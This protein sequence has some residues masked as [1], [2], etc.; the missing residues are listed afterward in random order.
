MHELKSEEFNIVRDM[1]RPFDY[2]LSIRAAL[3]GNNPARMF[4][5][6]PA[7]PRTLLAI[8]GEGT[9]LAGDDRNP[10]T[11]EKLRLLFKQIFTGSFFPSAEWC[12]TLSVDPPTWESWLPDLIPTHE[13]DRLLRFHY[14][15]KHLEYTDYRHHLPEGYTLHRIDRALADRFSAVQ[16]EW[17]DVEGSWGTVESFLAKGVGFWIL[18]QD[19]VVARCTADCAAGNQ[20]EVGV[21]TDPA[22]RRK[23]LA[24]AATAAT[25]EWCLQNGFTTVGW[26]CEH[27]NYGSWRTAEKVGFQ[28]ESEYPAFFYIFDP[29]DNLAQLGWSCYKRGEYARTTEYY[30]QVF[31]SREEHPYY[32]YICA[33]EAW[34]ALQNPDMALKYLKLAAENGWAAY[35]NTRQEE[36]FECLHGMPEWYEVLALIKKNAG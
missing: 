28:R 3:E 10:T 7:N 29:T 11:I 8:T 34:G 26:H 21:T 12:I 19:Q 24:T 23:G 5:D 36:L 30:E 1:L 35:E 6:D 32:Y 22:H 14:Q 9:F 4:V 15:C 25:V 17:L 13:P 31:S 20:I 33:A 18:H 2:S 27:D 16:D